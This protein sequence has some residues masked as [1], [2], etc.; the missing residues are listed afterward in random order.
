MK[1]K[2]GLAVI[3]FVYAMMGCTPQTVNVKNYQL[4]EIRMVNVG[5][6]MIKAGRNVYEEMRFLPTVDIGKRFAGEEFYLPLTPPYDGIYDAENNAYFV[7]LDRHEIFSV[8]VD[9]SGKT[10]VEQQ[11]FD[12]GEKVFDPVPNYFG[13]AESKIYELSYSGRLDDHITITYKEFYVDV[14]DIKREIS[15]LRPGFS[16][17]IVYNMA[18]SNEIVYKN[19]RLKVYDATN[20]HIEFEIVS[21]KA[22]E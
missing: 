12:K 6:P 18:E 13:A 14:R 1:K 19:F 22:N 5:D 3:L 11:Y 4:H 21:D 16:E 7:I 2:G 20:E 17:Q 10:L 9:G 15:Q 8:K